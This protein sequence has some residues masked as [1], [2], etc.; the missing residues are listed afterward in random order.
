MSFVIV[1]YRQLQRRLSD[2]GVEA[3]TDDTATLDSLNDS[4]SAVI[5]EDDDSMPSLTF[6]HNGAV[7]VIRSVS[8]AL[9]TTNSN[10]YSMLRR[11]QCLLR[12]PEILETV[13]R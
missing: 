3:S 8:D 11:S 2:A 10:K 9:E 1:Y 7:T 4:D 5:L 12:R 13:Y 6:Q